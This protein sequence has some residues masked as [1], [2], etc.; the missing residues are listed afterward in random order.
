M[1]RIE[2]HYWLN[3]RAIGRKA[4]V[5]RI[6]AFSEDGAVTAIVTLGRNQNGS[7]RLAYAA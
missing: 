4:T 3:G 7:Y 2:I 6:E 1:V 5:E